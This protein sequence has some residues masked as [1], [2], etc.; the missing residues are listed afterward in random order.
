M[1]FLEAVTGI[2]LMLH[3][4][5]TISGAYLS[6]QDITHL[7]PY[8]FLLRNLH[9]WCGQAMVV[10]VV[11]HMSRV[12]LTGSFAPPRR[13]NWI[14]GLMLMIGTLLVDFTGYLLVWDERALWARTIAR[15]LVETVPVLGSGVAS[16][17]F[18]SPEISDA[19]IIRLYVWHIV[20]IP[21][22][23]AGLMGWHL[24]KVR[25]DGGISGPL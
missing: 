7:I 4:V 14:I 10:L 11:L 6:I 15:N 23:M 3:Y 17:L 12:F 19:A 22:I 18:G 2:L 20:L 16:M 1:F 8:G 13:F 24:W 21:G 5:P 25:R 9:Y